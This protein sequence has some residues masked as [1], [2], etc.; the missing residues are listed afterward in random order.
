MAK[1]TNETHNQQQTSDANEYVPVGAG[2]AREHG[3]L[4]E[5]TRRGAKELCDQLGP[6]RRC[7]SDLLTAK[8][9]THYIRPG[10]GKGEFPPANPLV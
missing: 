4:P 5:C 6:G 1:R 3:A 9:A 8:R 2:A 7:R 10:V